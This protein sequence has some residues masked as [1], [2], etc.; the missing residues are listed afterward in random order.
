M[1]RL[2]RH[3]PRILWR[4]A[5]IG[6]PRDQILDGPL[7]V[8][9]DDTVKPYKVLYAVLPGQRLPTPFHIDENPQTR[10][11]R[12]VPSGWDVPQMPVS[13]DVVDTDTFAC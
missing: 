10:V 5:P 8:N 9:R 7:L 4:P 12:L 11:W 1:V 2:Y 13:I 6:E 3:G